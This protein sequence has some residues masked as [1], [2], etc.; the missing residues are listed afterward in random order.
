MS[1][2]FS[3][4][5]AG[6]APA[7]IVYRDDRVTAF[8]DINPAAPTHILVVPNKEIPT[9]NDLEEE[10]AALVGHMVLVAR[11]L[12]REEGIA[13]RGYRL[14][15]NCNEEGGQVV[16]HLHLHLLGGRPLGAMVKRV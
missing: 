11:R 14:I 2:I 6:E 16:F 9:V 8:R 4:I 5:I 1:T 3:K 7:D 15:I 12:A 10:D 13:E